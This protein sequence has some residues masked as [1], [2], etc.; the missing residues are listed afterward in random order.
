MDATNRT[1]VG[2]DLSREI[3]GGSAAAEANGQAAD[4]LVSRNG[5][6]ALDLDSAAALDE[7]SATRLQSPKAV[8]RQALRYVWR[9]VRNRMK[10]GQSRQLLEH[11]GEFVRQRLTVQ[12]FLSIFMRAIRVVLAR[13]DL[14]IRRITQSALL[15][16]S[17]SLVLT[18]TEGRVYLARVNTSMTPA[19]IAQANLN[20]VVDALESTGVD[21]FLV[22]TV[23]YRR[24]VGVLKKDR[25]RALAAIRNSPRC[26]TGYVG[27]EGSPRVRRLKKIHKR[28]EPLLYIFEAYATPGSTLV[29]ARD[30]ACELEFWDE[31]GKTLVTI[32]DNDVCDQIPKKVAV[33]SQITIGN[34]RYRSLE[35]FTNY[36]AAEEITFPIDVVY[37]W[38]DGNDP[39]WQARRRA[40]AGQ[41]DLASRNGQANNRS[42]YEN[43]DELR[44]S[45][46]SLAMFAPFVRHVYLV[47]DDQVP[48]WL[49]V[50]APGLTLV[51]H[52]ELFGDTGRLPT[53]NSHAIE[54][55]LHRIEGLSE[56]FIYFNDDVFLGRLVHPNLFFHANG[57]SKIFPSRTHVSLGP[58]DPH[59]GPSDWG[60]KNARALLEAHLG[61]T[62]TQKTKHV[63][64]P[65]RRSV[66]LELEAR[67]PE[68]FKQTACSQFRS[69]SDIAPISSLYKHYAWF[70]GRAVPGAIRYTY[71]N[72]GS[73]RL[74]WALR[75]VMNRPGYDI[76]CLNDTDSRDDD[77][78]DQRAL[79]TAF[80]KN[81]YPIPSDFEL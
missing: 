65:I 59:D 31:Q 40:A 22:K 23:R 15:R 28:R 26:L 47:T 25:E 60:A 1:R 76:F 53:F 55:R 6:R 27:Y 43:R 69:P 52:R 57:V 49:N 12:K 58:P 17:P 10:R 68:N 29:M 51:S 71:L 75:S 30:Y 39:A 46:R 21:Y 80:L 62:I 38:V 79:I 3:R 33:P 11:A 14:S 66:M 16:R 35:P 77:W 42:R 36:P 7:S 18:S 67:F 8:R 2:N 32:N 20:L 44:Y 63:A 24:R 78:D 34:R 5:D 70:T 72:V 64:M 54:S 56:H 45:M 73:A 19:Q 41:H 81:W 50:Y 9:R 61:R 74:P 48:P 4:R 13:I 37:T